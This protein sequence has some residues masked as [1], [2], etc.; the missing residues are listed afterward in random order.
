[1]IELYILATIVAIGYM[2]NNTGDNE[3]NILSKTPVNEV[4]SQ[5]NIYES[6][7]YNN[8][9]NVLKKKATKKYDLSL[10]P[11]RNRVINKNYY[12]EKKE[13]DKIL[14][15]SGEYIDKKDFIH[16]NMTPFYGGNVKQNVDP[17]VNRGVLENF[18]GVK[19]LQNC[20]KETTSFSDLKNNIAF[21]NGMTD[22]ADF[23]QDR[24]VKSTIH[25][26]YFPVDKIYVGPGLN[27]G[28]DS[29]P[30]GGF[31]QFEVNEFA[32]DKCVDQLRTQLNPNPMA[33]GIV[34]TRKETY[35][36]RT[37]DGLKTS[38][39]PNPISI[40]K[41]R[42][43][44]YYKQTP[45]MFMKTTGANLKESK[46]GTFNVKDT[47]RLTTT[48]DYVGTAKAKDKILQLPKDS[49][50]MPL[51]QDVKK[52]DLGIASLTKMGLGSFFDHGKKDIQVYENERDI[53]STQ[54][55]QG[56]I[57]SLIKSLTVPIQDALKIPK[58]AESVVNPRNYGNMSI[59]FPSKI[60]IHDP[61]NIARTT[62][63]ETTIHDEIPSNIKGATRITMYDSDNIAKSTIR[64]TLENAENEINI[65]LKVP[66]P[67]I[68][69]LDKPKTTVKETTEGKQRLYGNIDTKAKGGA[70][71]TTEYDAKP[72][73]K[74]ITTDNDYYG[75]AENAIQ[76]GAY[77]TTEYDAKPTQK[78]YITD[79]DYYGVAESSIK[80]QKLYDDI[81]TLEFRDTKENTLVEREPVD[82]GAKNFNEIWGS[83]ELKKIESD[84]VRKD[85]NYV[86]YI[87]NELSSLDENTVTNWRK[88][89]DTELNTR[90][91]PT[92][93]SALDDNPF[94]LKSFFKDE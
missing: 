5:R 55:Y 77:E 2:L 19:D 92:M 23:F 7:Y 9:D 94:A 68:K 62:I 74:E 22:N 8:A 52:Q 67:T 57:T 61:T 47:N 58:K 44:R 69:P 41:N 81:D 66:K 78:E 80:K 24:M 10:D 21:V 32:Q 36:S 63:K 29:K 88:N 45:D 56:N 18:T 28:Y 17:T 82:Q 16:A 60:T 34:D 84:N 35:E 37:V 33:I 83:S 72:T 91:D 73:Q 25:N 13:E 40:P 6:T 50:R 26:N 51:K 87:Y 53:T 20:K 89:Q 71:E 1:M 31:Q 15:L 39:P 76:M 38:L 49:Y 90:L 85:D 93:I 59:T 79:N 86:N 14:S 46:I 30:S 48:V 42:P 3:V 75:I 12:H 70:Y 4:P 43:D 64:Q 65:G 27:Q 54:T 11:K